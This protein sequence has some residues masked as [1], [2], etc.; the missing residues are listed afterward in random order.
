MTY[1]ETLGA[2]TAKYSIW[3]PALT[4][5]MLLFFIISFILPI[6]TKLFRTEDP[7]IKKQLF[8]Q[9][10]GFIIIIIWVIFAVF[11]S[12]YILRAIRPFLMAAGWFIWSITLIIDPFNI[13][14]SNA[15]INQL[16][17]TTDS[18]LP[19]YYNDFTS[20]KEEVKKED[21]KEGKKEVSI[22]LTSG[23]I[24]G[25]TKALEEIMERKSELNTVVYKDKVIGT[26]A[27][28]FLQAYVFGERFDKTLETVLNVLLRELQENPVLASKIDPGFV[29][30]DETSEKLLKNIVEQNLKR[31]LII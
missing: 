20:D 9:V 4:A 10:V 19:V 31:V 24:S 30:F 21:E 12:N 28:G 3:I 1:S 11:S 17:I 7:D 27:T 22:D 29:N 2:W 8:V 6:S 23:L 5:P 18:G 14:I 25:V 16:L 15:K 13:M 26:T